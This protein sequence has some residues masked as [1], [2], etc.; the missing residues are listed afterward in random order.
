MPRLTTANLRTEQVQ[1]SSCY[2][3]PQFDMSMRREEASSHLLIASREFPHR[4]RPASFQ[5]PA[6]SEAYGPSLLSALETLLLAVPVPLARVPLLALRRSAMEC[7][8]HS[9]MPYPKLMVQ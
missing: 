7:A 4:C 2:P 8:R 5:Y 9:A 1:T 6:Q 3:L